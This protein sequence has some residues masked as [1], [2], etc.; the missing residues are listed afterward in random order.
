MQIHLK[1]SF[2]QALSQTKILLIFPLKIF[3]FYNNNKILCI[4][5]INFSFVGVLRYVLCAFRG[6][7]KYCV[8][9]KGADVAKVSQ[10]RF[11]FLNSD[12]ND[13]RNKKSRFRVKLCFKRP[14]FSLKHHF[15]IQRLKT[16]I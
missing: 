4:L 3:D 2:L 8:T 15:T 7:F 12:F 6:P 14:L 10:K 1:N 11:M 5:H 16:V 13:L 9:F